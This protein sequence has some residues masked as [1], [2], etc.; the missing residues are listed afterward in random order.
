MKTQTIFDSWVTYPSIFV[1]P[2]VIQPTNPVIKINSFYLGPNKSNDMSLVSLIRTT[3]GKR[4]EKLLTLQ[5]GLISAISY[6]H[7]NNYE[8]KLELYN[9]QVFLIIL[10]NKNVQIIKDCWDI[11]KIVSSMKLKNPTNRVITKNY[12][13]ELLIKGR[14]QV[15]FN[16]SKT[17]D[18]GTKWK[19]I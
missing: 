6:T 1:K 4:I 18:H 11:N 7:F 9:D 14:L 5:T 13:K 2:R 12:V 8:F 3:Y 16:V 19:V 17:K 15:K 10:D